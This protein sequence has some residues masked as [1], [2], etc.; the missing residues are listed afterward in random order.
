[1]VA[2]VEASDIRELELRAAGLHIRL[3]RTGLLPSLA[4]SRPLADDRDADE[5]LPAV[6][7]PLTGIWYDAPAPGAPPYVRV[8]DTIEVGFVIGLVETMKVFNEV[9]ADVAGVVRQIL[10]HRGELITS[11]APILLLEPDANPGPPGEAS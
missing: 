7:S 9:T 10:V 8:G 6:R 1:V 4:Q 2:A 5:D 11:N 3:R